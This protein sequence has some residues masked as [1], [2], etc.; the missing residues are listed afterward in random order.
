[1]TSLGEEIKDWVVSASDRRRAG[2]LIRY[3]IVE[4]HHGGWAVHAANL[5]TRNGWSSINLF[6]AF[7]LGAGRDLSLSL[8]R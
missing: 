4:L 5:V 7:A 8:S 6:I 2:V 3:F 1:M